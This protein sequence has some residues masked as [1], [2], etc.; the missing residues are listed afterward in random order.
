MIWVGI[1]SFFFL[2]EWTQYVINQYLHY[3][4]KSQILIFITIKK[5]KRKIRPF[6]WNDQKC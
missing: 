2:A 4:Y 3:D 1:F 6:S 5:L